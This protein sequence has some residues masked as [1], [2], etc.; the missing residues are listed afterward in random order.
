MF[1]THPRSMD[2]I[3]VAPLLWL[4]A[5]TVVAAV[6][7][8][9]V[10]SYTSV[11]KQA[12]GSHPALLEGAS[13]DLDKHFAHASGYVSSKPSISNEEKLVLY[14][15]FKQATAGNCA[16][17]E[18][19]MLD[20][21]AKA[22]WDAWQALAGMPSVEAKK[23]YLEVVS[24]MFPGYAYDAPLP[25]P[26]DDVSDTE[27]DLGGDMSLAPL[28]SQ[29]VVDKTTKEWQVEEN[30]FHFAKTGQVEAVQGLVANA[31]DINQTDDE[32]RTMLHWAVDRN[33]VDV[34]ATLLAQHANVNATDIDGMTPLHYAVTCEHVALVDLLLEHG[35]DPEQ[36]DVDGE[37]P[38]AAASTAF[39]AHITE[40][41]KR[42]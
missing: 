42:F 31:T 6:V 41:L 3:K 10:F 35:A 8:H 19:S 22:K 16:G 20:F 29:V 17:D 15:F 28:M 33:Q 12:K 30:A 25:P 14:A 2:A 11:P 13:S 7:L 4:G 38:F 9:N 32:G 39:Q 27:S 37:S 34:V 23:R 18:P 24:S 1:T 26:R 36:V 21:V 40:S 5:A